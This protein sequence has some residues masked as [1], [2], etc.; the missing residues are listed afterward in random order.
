MATTLSTPSAPAPP[1]ARPPRAVR[2]AVNAKLAAAALGIIAISVAGAAA[3]FGLVTGTSP[4]VVAA[5][6][7]AKGQV[8]GPADLT[9]AAVAVDPSVG[10]VPGDQLAE[11]V[12]QR[13]AVDLPTGALL[14]PGS[15][16]SDPVPGPG[17]SLIGI[18][19]SSAQAPLTELAP[20]TPVRLI[21]VT[22]STDSRE[23][24]DT[25]VSALVVA[26]GT[27]ADGSRVVDVTV[28][29]AAAATVSAWAAGGDV[30]VVV[31]TVAR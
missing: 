3:L 14:A 24:A 29:A 2:P 9:T 22:E 10:V 5:A 19:V 16:T 12:G 1:A 15:A 20:G 7:L 23:R 17:R 13:A 26:S 8:I 31:D 4:V 11:L 28:A 25:P 21:H 6:P 27:A 18:Q 30:A